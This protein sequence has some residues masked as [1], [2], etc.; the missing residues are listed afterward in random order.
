MIHCF[1]LFCLAE[2]PVTSLW[3]APPRRLP[4]QSPLTRACAMLMLPP[5]LRLEIYR[6]LIHL[7]KIHLSSARLK[8]RQRCFQHHDMSMTMSWEY[9]V[10][11]CVDGGRR[12]KMMSEVA[13]DLFLYDDFYFKLRFL[14]QMF[15]LFI[16]SKICSY[17]WI[18]I[19]AYKLTSRYLFWCYI[20]C[21]CL[22]KCAYGS[23]SFSPQY[24]LWNVSW[25]RC[26]LMMPCRRLGYYINT[27]STTITPLPSLYIWCTLNKT[28]KTYWGRGLIIFTSQY[29]WSISCQ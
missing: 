5:L 26:T 15:C 16:Y 2:A 8:V 25:A 12:W 1:V 27:L 7:R 6:S 14:F 10:T 13:C 18:K 9:F 29:S 17:I 4:P 20:I 21:I 28:T 24:Q 11:V 3:V 23:Q 19:F 22:Y